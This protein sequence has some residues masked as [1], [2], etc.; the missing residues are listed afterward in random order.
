MDRQGQVLRLRRAEMPEG[1]I[2][3]G[4]EGN[5]VV[6]SLD[7][8]GKECAHFNRAVVFTWGAGRFNGA[9]VSHLKGCFTTGPPSV[10]TS[11][12]PPRESPLCLLVTL[13]QGRGDQLWKCRGRHPKDDVHPI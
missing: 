10:R 13:R 7:V 11:G 1:F 9:I 5:D 4:R 2:Q 3:E 8:S 6:I 12:N